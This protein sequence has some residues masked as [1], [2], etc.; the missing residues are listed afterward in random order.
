MLEKKIADSNVIEDKTKGNKVMEDKAIGNKVIGNKA[1]QLI[2][3]FSFLL[4]IFIAALIRCRSHTLTE[5]MQRLENSGRI[6][7]DIIIAVIDS[8]CNNLYEYQDRILA[9]YDFVQEDSI[10]DDTFGHGT[11]IA[12]LILSNTPGCIRIMPLKAADENGYAQAW[13]VCRALEYAADKGADIVNLSLNA[14]INGSDENENLNSLIT[15]LA[16]RG[17]S[18]ERRVGKEC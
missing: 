4:L 13:D 6:K 12:D 16:E 18:E 7:K 2:I 3:I 17:R 11:Q 15:R 10:P 8:G 14:V 9:G 5:Y 1:I